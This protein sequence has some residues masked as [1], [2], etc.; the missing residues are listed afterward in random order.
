MD[1]ITKE[2][3]TLDNYNNIET[4]ALISIHIDRGRWWSDSDFGSELYT[5]QGS[6]T[7]KET[8][9]VVR[10]MLVE[11]LEWL[12]KENLAKDIEVETELKNKNSIYYKVTITRPNEKNTIIED[13]WQ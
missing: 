10:R 3:F 8:A 12:K 13:I 2:E 1:N 9:S 7:N 4:L 5:L 6:K 11:C